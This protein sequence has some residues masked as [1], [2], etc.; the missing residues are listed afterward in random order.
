MTR[1]FDVGDKVLL[2]LPTESNKLLLQ[3]KGAYE[4]VEVI[5]RMDYKIDV[6]DVV[7]PYHANMLK[8]YIERQKVASHF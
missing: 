8:Q 5:N 1:K 7:N 6:T 4:I 2:L 3:W